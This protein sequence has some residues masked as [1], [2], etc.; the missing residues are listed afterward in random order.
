MMMAEAIAQGKSAQRLGFYFDQTACIGCRTCQIAC[1][2]KYDLPLGVLY[3]TVQTY[4]TG[5]FPHPTVFNYTAACNQCANP[6]CAAACPEGAMYIAD[7]GTVQHDDDLCI[8]CRKCMVA[9]PYGGLQ[10]FA[11]VHK[12]RKC[13]ACE[14]LLVRG[15]NPACVDACVMRCLEFGPLDELRA[16]HAGENLTDSISV[17]P[18][19]SQTHPS[20]LINPIEAALEDGAVLKEM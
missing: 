7:D 2:D 8:G 19:S 15:Q 1:N 13:D 18:D 10:Y 6:A 12:V 4:E 16:R 17:L 5:T 3:R 14:D 11:D 9:C 20:V